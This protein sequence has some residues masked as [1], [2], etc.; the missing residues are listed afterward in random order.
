[1]IRPSTAGRVYLCL[2]TAAFASAQN[3]GAAT[4]TASAPPTLASLEQNVKD[5]TV[6][7]NRLAQSLE[8]SLVRLL[9]CDPKIAASINAVIKASDARTAAIAAY[10][11]AA[12]RQAQLQASAAQ[13]VLASV[14][15]LDVDLGAEKSDLAPERAGL[16]GQL[17]NLTLSV[18]RRA[19]LTAPQDA[20]K[21]IVALQQQR[22]DAVD[23]AVTHAD[24]SAADLA[25]VLMQLQAR[26]AA[27]AELQT[28]FGTEATRWHAYYAARLA[29]AQ[30]ECSISK[31]IVPAAK[32]ATKGK[33]Q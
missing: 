3:Q 8:G 25:D 24:A 11:S 1:M 20:L 7:W 22:S 16:D 9:P 26:Q 19:S 28:A 5:R 12:D 14:K 27:L 13:Q 18:Q 17:A 15:G 33:K 4:Q 23:A 32:G 30:M 31:G 29:R 6:E 10:L 2:L 21:Q